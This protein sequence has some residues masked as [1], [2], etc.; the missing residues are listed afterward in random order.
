[1]ARHQQ[2]PL[3]VY[4]LSHDLRGPLNS[5]LGF[6]E[7]LLEGIEGPLNENQTEDITAIYQSAH[8]LLLLINNLVDLS[9]LEAKRID[10]DIEPVDLRQI[11]QKVANFDFGPAK[12]A[13]TQLVLDLPDTPLS[14]AGDR[15][16]LEQM[17]IIL[18]RFAFKQKRNGLI[19]LSAGVTAETVTLYLSLGERVIPD[20]ELASLFE[21]VVYIDQ[22]GRSELGR[23][24]LE[25]PVVRHLVENH[26]GRV[27]AENEAG[28][29]TR[30]CIELPAGP[31]A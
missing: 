14:L 1:M 2:Q 31:A 9:K 7:L 10:F 5:I 30:L 20:S 26:Q 17:L 19:K 4:H 11:L 16:R 3:Q 29:G 28:V 24:G 25:L 6:A 18:S 13:Q 8:N 21:S 27:W 23:G 15:V 12:P 22:A